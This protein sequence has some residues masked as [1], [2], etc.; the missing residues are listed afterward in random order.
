MINPL[1][2]LRF[3]ITKNKC[4]VC[5]E[6]GFSQ[7]IC[8]RQFPT[9]GQW[10]TRVIFMQMFI[11][12][13]HCI[14]QAHRKAFILR[15]DLL[16]GCHQ[17]IGRSLICVQCWRGNSEWCIS[18]PCLCDLSWLIPLLQCLKIDPLLNLG[19]HWSCDPT[20]FLL[21]FSCNVF[22]SACVYSLGLLYLIVLISVSVHDMLI[23]LSLSVFV[24]CFILNA[25][26]LW[27]WP[28]SLLPSGDFKEAKQT[29]HS[30]QTDPPKRQKGER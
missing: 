24:C 3:L 8:F 29:Q 6:A 12:F 2:S 9:N 23:S 11:V 14:W 22:L 7:Y 15:I 10:E 4:S 25:A 5:F 26:S 20:V 18:F 13:Q 17:S 27:R 21:H 19:N 28:V 30:Y 16:L 1:R